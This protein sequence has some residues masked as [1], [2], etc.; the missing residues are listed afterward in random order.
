MTSAL[1]EDS[2]I[3]GDTTIDSGASVRFAILDEGVTVGKNAVV[4]APLAQASDVTVIGTGVS[5]P[6]GAVVPD[7]QMISEL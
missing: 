6:A 2:V 7:G 3:M 5:I 1:V 4:G